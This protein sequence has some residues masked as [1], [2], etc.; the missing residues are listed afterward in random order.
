[1]MWQRLKEF[2]KEWRYQSFYFTFYAGYMPLLLYLPV[3]LKHVGLSTVHVGILN[4]LRPILQSLVTPLLVI[5]GEKL[6]SKKLLFVIS[7]FIAIA[8]ILVMYLLIRP[9]RQ[10]CIKTYVNNSGEPIVMVSKLVHVSLLVAGSMSEQ[11]TFDSR[12]A[13]R[14]FLN[15]TM[16]S[17]PSHKEFV[18]DKHTETGTETGENLSKKEKKFGRALSLN[19]GLETAELIDKKNVRKVSRKTNELTQEKSD[20]LYNQLAIHRIFVALVLLTIIADPFI[21]AIFTL[22]DYSC[23]ANNAEKTGRGYRDVRLWETIGWGTMTPI[24]G[25]VIY[26]QGQ[27]MCGF[28]VETYHYTFFFYVGFTIIALTIGIQIDLTQKMPEAISNKI[29]SAHS[30]LQYGMFSIVSA[31]AGF[32]HGF[33][34][35]FVNWFIDILGG[36][37]IIMGIA[38]ASKSVID[39]V[40]YFQL[41]RLMEKLGYVYTVSLGLLGHIAVFV[42][43]YGISNAWLVILP[44][45]IYGIM[46]SLLMSTCASFLVNVAPAGSSAR[47]QGI[48]FDFYF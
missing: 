25:L 42:M 32:G 43:Y 33:L 37:T 39:L 16:K 14:E 31:F 7:C 29:H 44:E 38:A 30:N 1:M 19:R 8:K 40:L 20:I 24:I 23:A 36:N 28:M 12:I 26:E 41:G 22:V 6:R 35:T 45:A 10:L 2:V 46:Y 9:Q 4:G 18:P 11:Q 34:L 27:Q 15:R 13:R 17:R 21:A 5:V 48:S 47:M 3:Y